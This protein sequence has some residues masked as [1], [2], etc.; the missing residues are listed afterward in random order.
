MS[1]LRN[2][3]PE[4]LKA[5]PPAGAPPAADAQV[6]LM[7]DPKAVFGLLYAHTVIKYDP[8]AG[9][10]CL[11]DALA[12]ACEV[13]RREALAEAGIAIRSLYQGGGDHGR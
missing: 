13:G 11:R 9:E 12:V 3:M 5:G 8:E 2:R 4:S 1:N 6:V 7:P 10:K